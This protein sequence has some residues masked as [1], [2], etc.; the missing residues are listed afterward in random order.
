MKNDTLRGRLGTHSTKEI[1]LSLS[2]ILLVALVFASCG[3]STNIK[4]A[5]SVIVKVGTAQNGR[6][7]KSVD[8]SG[9]FAPSKTFSIYSKLS[10]QAMA[11]MA[12][13][14]DTVKEGQVLIQIDA[15]E[16]N[17]QL[18]VAQAAVHSVKDQTS[19]AET[20]LETAKSNMDLAQITFD[21]AQT[22]FDA[23]VVP[24]SQL[25]D[26]QNKLTQT[27]M[28]YETESKRL[29]TLRG[30]GLAQAEAQENLI[31]VQITNS[32]ITSPISGVLINRNINRGEV[33]P[34]GSPLMTIADI[35]TLKLQGN[36]SQDTLPFLGLG[37]KVPVTVDG[38]QGEGIMGTITQIGPMA[39]A[40]G[41]YFPVVVSVTNTGGL[42][43]GMTASGQLDLRGPEGLVIPTLAV[44]SANGFKAVFVIHSGRVERRSVDLGLSND[45]EVQV[46]KGL[47][48]GENVAVANANM[49]RDGMTVTTVR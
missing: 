31:Q 3:A 40:T 43:A 36:V 39:A 47:A 33:V 24:Q 2:A 35:S 7:E 45:H 26:A 27:K 8:V 5:N 29:Q 25:D 13:V 1:A 46:R 32:I 18:Q 30:S 16:L 23:K 37:M 34:I 14:G 9:V 10:G 38:F 12:D 42:L 44:V 19:Q 41:Q 15:K 49:L 4:T 6:I 28:A 11:V 22:L 21:R 17:A 48:S 20:S